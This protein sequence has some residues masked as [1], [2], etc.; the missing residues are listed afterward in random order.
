MSNKGKR[1]HMAVSK[2]DNKLEAKFGTEIIFAKINMQHQCLI[3]LTEKISE[4][5]FLCEKKR[6]VQYP[7]DFFLSEDFLEKLNVV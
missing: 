1:N 7:I 3:Y 5:I 6:N 4:L 2:E